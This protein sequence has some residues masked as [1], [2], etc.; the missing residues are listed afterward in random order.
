MESFIVIEQVP[1]LHYSSPEIVKLMVG[2]H[3]GSF[4]VV[5]LV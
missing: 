4:G 1:T 3:Y 2:L 5:R